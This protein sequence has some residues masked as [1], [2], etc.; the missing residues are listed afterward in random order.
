MTALSL[1]DNA[2]LYVE[3]GL[4]NGRASVCLSVCL[5]HREM[6]ATTAGGFAAERPVGRRY[7]S[8]AAGAK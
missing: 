2:A 8:I 4:C 3:Q 1:V 5:S 7:R 6:A